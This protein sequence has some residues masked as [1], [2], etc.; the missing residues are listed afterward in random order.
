MNLYMMVNVNLQHIKEG[1]IIE[2]NYYYN[3]RTLLDEYKDITATL[4]FKEN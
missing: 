4:R 3:I 2:C 1:D